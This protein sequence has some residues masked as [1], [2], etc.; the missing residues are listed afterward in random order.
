MVTDDPQLQRLIDRAKEAVTEHGA[1]PLDDR[2]AEAIAL[3]RFSR[4]TREEFDLLNEFAHLA[5][6]G[7]GPCMREDVGALFLKLLNEQPVPRA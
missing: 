2:Q 3:W 6:E 5:C 7:M 4:L 1:A